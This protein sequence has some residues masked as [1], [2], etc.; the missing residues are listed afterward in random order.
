MEKDEKSKANPRMREPGIIIYKQS[1]ILENYLALS[2]LYLFTH[3]IL[4]KYKS[5]TLMY[6]QEDLLINTSV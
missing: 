5:F 1:M 6:T 2:L 4:T 3:D